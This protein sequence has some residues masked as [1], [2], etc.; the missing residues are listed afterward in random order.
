MK[1]KVGIVVG[2]IFKLGLWDY[3]YRF[4]VLGF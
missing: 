1:G 4:R 2:F 3:D